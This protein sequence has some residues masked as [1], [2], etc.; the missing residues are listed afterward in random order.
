MTEI[1]DAD[2]FIL[3]QVYKPYQTELG[4]EETLKKQPFSNEKTIELLSEASL[5]SQAVKNRIRRCDFKISQWVNH[6]V[7]NFLKEQGIVR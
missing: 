3:E 1:I 7:I 5:W 4:F 6:P 2:K